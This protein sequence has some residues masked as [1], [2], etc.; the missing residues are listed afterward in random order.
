MH[1]I[2]VGLVMGIICGARMWYRTM[3]FLYGRFFFTPAVLL[4]LLLKIVEWALLGA[5]IGVLTSL[6][7]QD[8]D[9]FHLAE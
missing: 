7:L 1:G 5:A 9:F 4:G 8:P 3:T 2:V 6:L